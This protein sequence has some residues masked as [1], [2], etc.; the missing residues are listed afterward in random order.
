MMAEEEPTASATRLAWAFAGYLLV[1]WPCTWYWTSAGYECDFRRI[2]DEVVEYW[3]ILDRRGVSKNFN[4][5]D[6]WIVVDAEGV[7]MI[8]S[9]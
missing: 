1:P 3:V 6:W 4:V 7:Y 5:T 9:W 2:V 8:R